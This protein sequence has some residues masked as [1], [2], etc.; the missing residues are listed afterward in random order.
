M[1]TA[2][3]RASATVPTPEALHAHFLAILPRIET[4][5]RIYFRH[6]RCPG[7]RDDAVAET[8]AVAWKWSLRLHDRGKDVREFP[9]ALATLAA[10][11]VRSGRR[12][13]GKERAGDAMSA[14][15]QR[16]GGFATVPLADGRDEP[17]CPLAEALR[18]NAR[19]PVPD[20]AH[21]RLAM[22]PWLAS[23]GRR[24]RSI[25]L[26]LMRGFGTGAVAFRHRISPGRVSQMRSEFRRDWAR[27]EGGPAHA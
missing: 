8:V 5:A 17:G 4:H 19:T 10:R 23:L 7:R 22:P 26:D 6:I 9:A 18:D 1:T 16:A 12:L 21:F 24:R 11:H 14:A 3:R 20:Q 13:C 27:L 25:A 2:S 15:A